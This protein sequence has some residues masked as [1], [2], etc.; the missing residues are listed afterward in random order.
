MKKI[1]L[2]VAA[3]IAVGGFQANAIDLKGLLGNAG[4][5]V[6]GVVEG[7][8]T[9][10][11]ITVEQMAGN[12]TASGSAIAFQSDNFLQKAGGSA[13]ASA[14]ESKLNPYYEKY[15]LTGSTLDIQADGSF[16]MKVKGIS[17]K[18]NITK[19]GD[20]NFDFAFTPFGSFKLGSI[21]T[22]VEKT[23][24]GL[25]VMFDASKLKSLISTIAGFTG[26][27]L[28]STA[29]SLLDSYD[30]MLVGFAYTGQS[31]YTGGSG[32]GSAGG[33]VGSLLNGIFG[34]GSDGSTS[35][36]NAEEN[37][38]STSGETE[39]APSEGVNSEEEK[40]NASNL[41][42]NIFGK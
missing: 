6:S 7:L 31:T 27:S 37:V 30:G 41:L 8:L 18:G 35:T 9:Q 14:I 34:G 42:K 40:K 25:N 11:D 12:W 2:A 17:I 20:G 15:G 24:S 22:Y 33:G 19:R 28:A 26:N 10:S 23:P 39:T 38:N 1:I 29:G 21:V 13:A 3:A 16:V 5:A 32:A 4:S 36:Q